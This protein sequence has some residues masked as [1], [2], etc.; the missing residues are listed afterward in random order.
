MSDNANRPVIR[1]STSV[2]IWNRR[3]SYYLIELDLTQVKAITSN[4]NDMKLLIFIIFH[5]CM[6]VPMAKWHL[7]KARVLVW[8]VAGIRLHGFNTL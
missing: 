8:Q 5:H 7:A 4:T 6:Y 3:V 1:P 2:S